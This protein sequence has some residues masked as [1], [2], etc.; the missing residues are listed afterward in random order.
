MRKYRRVAC[1]HRW[2]IYVLLKTGISMRQAAKEINFHR[3][4]LYRERK[5]NQVAN[6]A[7]YPVAAQEMAKRRRKKC[8]KARKIK[9]EL[10]LKVVSLLCEQ[11]SPE[12]IAG[13]LRLEKG[14][15]ICHQSIYTFT[16][17][18]QLLIP[19]LRTYNKRGAGRIRQ[20]RTNDFGRLCISQRPRVVE[21]RKRLGDWERDGMYGANR[22]QLLACVE[23]KTRYLKISRVHPWT[24]KNVSK[25]SLAA[26]KST[27]APIHTITNDRGAE[28]GD[29]K[30]MKVPVYY[31]QPQTPNQRGT[32]ENTIGLVRQYIKRSTN[33]EEM[34]DKELKHIEDQINHRPRKCLNYKT[35]YEV[36]FKKNVALVY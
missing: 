21:G 12:Q 3:S 18:N 22:K 8:R 5:R 30:N 17:K 4:T 29:G 1:E 15:Q 24:A 25:V 33:L 16:K 11:W 10:E 9:G 36:L 31:C 14:G 19:L 7:Y 32:V 13:R 28:F 34:S 2:Q 6:G 23:R 35:P 20:R 26:M 27:K